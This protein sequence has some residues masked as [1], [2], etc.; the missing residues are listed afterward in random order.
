MIDLKKTPPF[1]YKCAQV[2]DLFIDMHIIHQPV[3]SISESFCKFTQTLSLRLA[4][5]KCRF[6][7]SP[8][9]VT[10]CRHIYII[11]MFL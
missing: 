11:M 9:K 4:A 6:T 1:R 8:H 3:R 7:A 2:T 10:V 5:C